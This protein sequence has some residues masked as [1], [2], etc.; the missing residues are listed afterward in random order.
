[1]AI[2]D[3]YYT[4]QH[5]AGSMYSMRK[6]EEGRSYPLDIYEMQIA[7]SVVGLPNVYKVQACHCPSRANPCKH[8][9]MAELLLD[10]AIRWQDLHHWYWAN[11]HAFK[12]EDL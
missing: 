10:A 1:M 2:G 9:E 11:G 12:A 4:L 3:I 8:F 5:R 7:Q 6:W